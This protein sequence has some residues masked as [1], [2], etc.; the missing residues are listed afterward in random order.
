MTADPDW[1]VLCP[2]ADKLDENGRVK[3]NDKLEVEGFENNNVYAIGDCCNTNE[4]KMATYAGTHG[5]TIAKNLLRELQGE[6]K[7]PYKAGKLWKYVKKAMQ[8]KVVWG[9][10]HFAC[11]T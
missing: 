9:E 11:P 10:M 7:L 6:E 4:E 5:D 8:F 3:V 1:P 2:G